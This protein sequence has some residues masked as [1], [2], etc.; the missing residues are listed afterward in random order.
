MGSYCYVPSW[1]ALKN[2]A[3]Q[4]QR[5]ELLIC[6]GELPGRAEARVPFSGNQVRWIGG[7]IPFTLV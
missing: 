6:I 3:I 4:D 7:E 2:D 5:R 1:L